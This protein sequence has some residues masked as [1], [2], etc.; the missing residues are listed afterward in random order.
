MRA[1]AD[2][3]NKTNRTSH[4]EALMAGLFDD[5]AAR[6]CE[7]AFIHLELAARQHPV[8]VLCALYN[9]N[10]RPCAIAHNDAACRMNGFARHAHPPVSQLV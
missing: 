3:D 10:Q 2:Q 7:R 9:G 1:L 6:A 8:P 5:L 4:R